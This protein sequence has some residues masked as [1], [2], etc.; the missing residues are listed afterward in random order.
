MGRDEYPVTIKSALYLLICTE[1]GIL[2]NQQSPTYEN[3]GG[4]GGGQHK[5]RIGHTFTQHKGGI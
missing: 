2:G 1:G 4:I 3:H 5:E